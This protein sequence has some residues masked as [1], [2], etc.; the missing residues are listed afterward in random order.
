[1]SKILS[2]SDMDYKEFVESE[3]LRICW[4]LVTGERVTLANLY[5][6]HGLFDKDHRNPFPPLTEWRQQR[7]VEIKLRQEGKDYTSVI[8]AKLEAKRW[9]YTHILSPCNN[10]SSKQF[11]SRCERIGGLVPIEWKRLY[12]YRRDHELLKYQEVLYSGARKSP[13]PKAKIE[14]EL[15]WWSWVLSPESS[16]SS[17]K[18]FVKKFESDASLREIRKLAAEIIEGNATFEQIGALE[19]VG[20]RKYAS[21]DARIQY[22]AWLIENRENDQVWEGDISNLVAKHEET[23]RQLAPTPIE[24]S[25]VLKTSDEKGEVLTYREAAYLLAY[26]RIIIKD[27]RSD[28]K[29]ES[30]GFAKNLCEKVK[31]SSGNQLY[32]KYNKIRYAKGRDLAFKDQIDLYAQGEKVNDRGIMAIINAV[33]KIFPRISNEY[34]AEAEEDLNRWKK[35]WL[36]M[37]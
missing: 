34:K 5:F 29:E 31:P 19:D 33:E 32:Q 20:W 28:P 27:S 14:R 6:Y 17:P 18:D 7:A 4:N 11:I 1:M 26:N 36:K 24:D 22:R 9:F 37:R 21:A 12:E 16:A 15:N 3:L 23:P 2:G 35:E 25:A 10:F 8:Q 30:K 13:Y